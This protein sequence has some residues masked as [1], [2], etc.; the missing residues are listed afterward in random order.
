MDERDALAALLRECREDWIRLA[1]GAS[2]EDVAA[3]RDFATRI[4]AALAKDKP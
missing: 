1:Y 4:D 2:H 3:Y